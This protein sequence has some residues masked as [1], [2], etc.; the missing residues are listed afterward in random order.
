MEPTDPPA[1][2]ELRDGTPVAAWMLKANPQV[3]DL[4]P[5]M[6]GR[7]R[8]D[9]WR[10]APGYRADLIAPGHPCALW[11]TRGDP[12]LPSGLW[13]VGEVTGRPEADV[14]DPDDERWRDEGARRR[15]RP[16]V[17]VRMRV[18][19]EP[20]RREELAA[21]PRTAGLEV[22]RLPRIGNPAA[23]TPGQWAALLELVPG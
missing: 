21:D 13:A 1:V 17:P 3:W 20:V 4:R 8:L 16:Y 19:G 6:A 10:L 18:L 5:T 9:R 7:D 22:L 12:R 15:V 14:G 11:I 2:A 23:V